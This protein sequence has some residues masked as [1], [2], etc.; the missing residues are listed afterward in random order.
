[1]NLSPNDLPELQNGFVIY[2]ALSKSFGACSEVWKKFWLFR[3]TTVHFKHFL[4]DSWR[5]R[6]T[7]PWKGKYHPSM[8][9]EKLFAICLVYCFD[10]G[11]IDY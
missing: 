10:G 8:V 6:T 9:M 5:V 4:N 7:F 11:M 1:M 2:L 3:A